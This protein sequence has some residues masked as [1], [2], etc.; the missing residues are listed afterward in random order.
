MMNSSD[1]KHKAQMHT[2]FY[3]VRAAMKKG[4]GNE[5]ATFIAKCET[6]HDHHD[7]YLTPLP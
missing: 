7:L 3:G 6:K 1:D 2:D 4:T 5:K